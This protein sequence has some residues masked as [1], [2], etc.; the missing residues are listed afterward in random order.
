MLLIQ[1]DF[2]AKPDSLPTVYR[3]ETSRAT[4]DAEITRKTLAGKRAA[5]YGRRTMLPA[6]P[7]Y[8]LSDKGLFSDT[9]LVSAHSQRERKARIFQKLAFGTK[10]KKPISF[11][12]QR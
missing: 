10:Y 2:A 12:A 9:S 11:G 4:S 3:R 5:A 8:A 6:L 1:S 7:H